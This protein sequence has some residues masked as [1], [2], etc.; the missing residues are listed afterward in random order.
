MPARRCS[1]R[2]SSHSVNQTI[3]KPSWSKTTKIPLSNKQ[4]SHQANDELFTCD[5]PLSPIVQ[6]SPIEHP[7]SGNHSNATTNATKEMRSQDYAFDPNTT[8]TPRMWSNILHSGGLQNPTQNVQFKQVLR[9]AGYRMPM[10]IISRCLDDTF[11]TPF[12]AYIVNYESLRGLV[13][14]NEVYNV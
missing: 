3:L 14:S 5:S 10:R 12:D 4:P 8:T 9:E 13:I 11:F 6:K 1:S 7:V 2:R